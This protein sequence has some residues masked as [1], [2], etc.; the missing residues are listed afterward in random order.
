MDL[1]GHASDVAP[2]L[3]GSILHGP[4][5]AGRIVEVEAYGGADDPASH[6]HRGPTERNRPMFGPAGTLYVYLIYGI[7]NCAN[8]VTGPVGDGQA[9]LIRALE[10]VGDRTAMERCRSRRGPELTNGPGKLCEALGVDRTHTGQ[11][12][13]DGGAVSLDLR[14]HA[15]SEPIA[16]ST[17][18]GITKATNRPWRWYLRGNRYVSGSRRGRGDDC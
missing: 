14:E 4:N 5:G 1:G 15:P 6:A 11:Y 7:H 18:V 3:L 13:L 10:P 8:V 17:R 9:V 12:L 16:S 2:L